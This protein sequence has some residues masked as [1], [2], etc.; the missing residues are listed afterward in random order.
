MR[1]PDGRSMTVA[2]G[3]FARSFVCLLRQEAENRERERERERES[4][5]EKMRLD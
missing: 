4:E 2:L 3:L 5:R 1:I